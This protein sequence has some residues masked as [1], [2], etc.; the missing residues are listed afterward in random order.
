M[1]HGEQVE[2]LAAKIQQYYLEKDFFLYLS[3]FHRVPTR[4]QLVGMWR[5]HEQRAS[6]QYVV[7]PFTIERYSQPA[8]EIFIDF[9][10]HPEPS[11]TIQMSLKS[12]KYDGTEDLYFACAPTD[13]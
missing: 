11:H 12:A 4:R 8:W 6:E 2:A 9:R 7:G 3:L 13:G 1:P 10:F 5:D